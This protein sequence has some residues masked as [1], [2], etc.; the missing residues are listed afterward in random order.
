MR[1]LDTSTD[2]QRHQ[3]HKASFSLAKVSNGGL[4]NDAQN[5]C[6][7]ALPWRQLNHPNVLPFLGIER[8]TQPPWLCLVSPWIDFGNI[9]RYLEVHSTVTSVDKLMLEITK[10]L[11]YLHSQFIIHGDLRGAN[12]LISEGHHALLADFGLVSW[13][14]STATLG[15]TDG[16]GSYRWMAQELL[17]SSS[18]DESSFR[19]TVATDIYS[20]ACVFLEIYTRRP[21]FW[22]IIYDAV[23]VHRVLQGERPT[24]PSQ[25]P[26]T[27][28]IRVPSCR[29]KLIELCWSVEP[30][31]RPT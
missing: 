28:D 7:E 18:Q 22:Y 10:G 17:E 11:A 26:D 5:L 14:N 1:V 3:I 16:R 24:H 4:T 21:P 8:D 23:V 20:L 9:L 6:R 2:N 15:A 29:W 19:R 13:A 25:D 12:I 30:G 27:K 31:R